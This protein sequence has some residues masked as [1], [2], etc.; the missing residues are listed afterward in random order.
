MIDTKPMDMAVHHLHMERENTF[1][2]FRFGSIPVAMMTR[3]AISPVNF[4]SKFIAGKKIGISM[5]CLRAD[6]LGFDR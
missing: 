3:K 4:G 2:L 5:R 1:A 6:P